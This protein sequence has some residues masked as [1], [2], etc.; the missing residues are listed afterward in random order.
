MDG[1]H[2]GRSKRTP[3]RGEMSSDSSTPDVREQL[4]RGGL[5]LVAQEGPADLSVR[6]L[7]KAADR[8]TMCIYSKFG[9][10]SGLIEAIYQRAAQEL[11]G[12][13]D[14]APPGFP[15][16][17]AA[18]HRHVER[19]AGAYALLFEQPLEAVDLERAVRTDLIAA[20]VARIA[21]RLE[22]EDA[23]RRDLAARTLW[24]TMHGLTALRGSDAWDEASFSAALAATLSGFTA[25]RVG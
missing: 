2:K 8:T 17:A 12:A 21:T 1:M 6:R 24:S 13:L 11:L 3:E 15:A 23:D 9:N 22:I 16:L 20:I 7:A 19:A 4:V 14:A 5:V 25:S 10:R 18:Y